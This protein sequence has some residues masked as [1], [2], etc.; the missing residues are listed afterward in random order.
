[1]ASLINFGQQWQLATS[2]RDNLIF[3]TASIFVDDFTVYAFHRHSDGQALKYD[4]SQDGGQTFPV[5]RSTAKTTSADDMIAARTTSFAGVP[6][7]VLLLQEALGL[8]YSDTVLTLPETSVWTQITLPGSL[9]GAPL[10]LEVAGANVQVFGQSGGGGAAKTWHSEDGGTTFA[11]PVNVGTETVTT[12]TGPN[13]L[14]S[15]SAGLWCLI[16][17]GAIFRSADN[18]ASWTPAAVH[19]ITAGN[20]AC[21]ASS[22]IFAVS[23]TRLVACF[24]G[25]VA[26]SD[27]A[28]A[29]WTD[30]QNLTL[31]P[32]ST[33]SINQGA[34]VAFASF[35]SHAGVP[36]LGAATV[37]PH[38]FTGAITRGA[39]WRSVDLGTTWTLVDCVGGTN[40][41]STGQRVIAFIARGGRGLMDLQEGG[42]PNRATFFNPNTDVAAV[43]ARRTPS[44]SSFTVRPCFQP[45]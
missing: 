7:R 22:A 31:N 29:T 36:V 21:P 26:T 33:T 1:M 18:G 25:Q 2:T 23:A 37:Y 4:V 34:L 35:G 8:L 20:V 38:E 30:R 3:S 10:G 27:D 16:N 5:V 6:F 42:G 40:L 24:K 15:P 43:A 19:T 44:A 9:V 12:A 13:H 45:C 11:G 39:F 14:C 41:A 17:K 28:G 32:P